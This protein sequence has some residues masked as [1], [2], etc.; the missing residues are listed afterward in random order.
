MMYA[1]I[2]RPATRRATQAAPP[3][4]PTDMKLVAV[5]ALLAGCA[6]TLAAGYDAHSHLSGPIANMVT[7][8]AASA[9]EDGPSAPPVDD[10]RSYSFALGA[11]FSGGRFGIELGTHLHD[12]NG[13]SFSLPS[14]MGV[15]PT[16]PRYLLATTS[17]DVRIR[18]LSFHHV[19]SE[20]HAGPA[21]GMLV[22]RAMIGKQFGNGYR[23]GAMV[24]GQLGPLN[25]FADVYETDM[26]FDAGEAK[27]M[28]TLTGITLGVALR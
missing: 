8:P 16:S 26:A 15:D 13:A 4:D 17:L 10:T 24:G 5:V 28:S 9:R 2:A 20:L 18:W 7:Q 12:V 14:A 19:V 27:G 22:D 11:G 6:P 3:V 21:A 23:F 1:R 25:V